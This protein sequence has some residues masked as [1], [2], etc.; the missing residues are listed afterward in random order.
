MN[1]LHSHTHET[2]ELVIRNA[3]V[4]DGTGAPAFVGDLAVSEGQITQVGKVTGIGR[5]EVDAQG[6]L[7]VP[8]FIDAHT[9]YDG[10]VRWDPLLT[11]SCWHGVTTTLFGNCGVGFAP[12]RPGTEDWLI[13]LMEG[14]E[15]IPGTS[16]AQGIRWDWESFPEY[17][18]VLASESYIMDIGVHVPHGPIRTYVM[19]E[20]ATGKEMPSPYEIQKMATLVTEAMAA[21]ALGFSTSR[22]L[23]HLSKDGHPVPGTFA[24][25]AELNA[26]A[27]AMGNGVFQVVPRGAGGED[28]EAP[29]R[30]IAWMEKL[31]IRNNCP[32]AFTLF[33]Y[34]SG[35]GAW[36]VWLELADAAVSRGAKLFPLVSGRPFGMLVGLKLA[37]PFSRYPTYLELNA[38]PHAQRMAEMRRPEVKQKILSE[39]PATQSPYA[40]MFPWDLKRIFPLGNPPNYEPTRDQSVTAL[41]E[42]LGRPE[43]DYLYDLLLE[44]E[45]NNLLLRP[46]FGYSDFNLEPTRHMMEHPRAIISLSDGGAHC[47][48][49]CDAS[50]PTS[51]L[52]HWARDRKQGPKLKL[53]RVIQMM[54]SDQA[55]VWGL[56]DRGVLKPGYKADFNLI[57]YDQ[58][59]LLPPEVAHDLPA[60]NRRIVQGAKG[61]LATYVSGV[62]T[63]QNG[64][65]T[66]ALPGRLVRKS[67][68]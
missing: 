41:A 37:N 26:L 62:L 9:H 68:A 54:T 44:N 18:K 61:Y 28:P 42:K 63:I 46:L 14:V 15:D 19:H 59:Q 21:G 64:I 5:K 32:V 7:L 13:G 55:A 12:V 22:T 49:I 10:Q 40:E 6:A 66:G 60:G 33:Q 38:L 67:S 25:E 51:M 58:L 2:H 43:M 23:N 8:G 1:P 24:D 11:P 16:L 45:G 30:E 57:D 31:S 65:P 39:K 17:M 4:M 27:A 36:K 56:N 35:P 52:T 50:L 3:T 53:E 29:Q 34:D 20:K 47:G 48:L